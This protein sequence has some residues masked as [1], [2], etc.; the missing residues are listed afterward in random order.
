[1]LKKS[2]IKANSTDD[3]E[4]NQRESKMTLKLEKQKKT[5]GGCKVTKT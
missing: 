3:G 4:S 2:Y 1:M 5:S